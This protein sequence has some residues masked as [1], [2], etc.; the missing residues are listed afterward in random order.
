[1]DRK[2][3]RRNVPKTRSSRFKRAKLKGGKQFEQNLAI[4]FI[5]DSNFIK[6]IREEV[7]ENLPYTIKNKAIKQIILWCL[8]YYDQY[9]KAPKLNIQDIFESKREDLRPAD[10]DIIKEFLIRL[11]RKYA[12]IDN[13]EGEFEINE[14][15]G[16]LHNARMEE[17][18]KR[19]QKLVKDNRAD[20]AHELVIKEGYVSESKSLEDSLLTVTEFINTKIK[21]PKVL[22]KP[23]LTASSLNMIYGLRGIG[24]S[25][26]SHILAISLTRREGYIN[27]GNW[28]TRQGASVLLVDGEMSKASIQQRL[29]YLIQSYDV[30]EGRKLFLLADDL[31]LTKKKQ[32]DSLSEI[33]KEKM[34]DVL[35]LD[36]ISCLFPGLDENS[37]QDWDPINRWLLSLRAMGLAVVLIHHAGKQGKQRG[38]SG[39]EDSLDTVIRLTRPKD[40]DPSQGARFWVYF[41]K[42]RQATPSANLNSFQIT[43]KDLLM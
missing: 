12:E 39:R 19:A 28:K 23:W 1:M 37:K 15:R 20:E 8:E 40:Y 7:E 42:A 16:L 13:F 29:K 33:A 10:E 18:L 27:I 34:I 21:R 24:K 32:R 11:S 35:F 4:G 2:R 41:D 25:W 3:N 6:E 36:N 31:N 9:E 30:G 14:V 17:V 22:V 38:T 5:T 26:L 43:V